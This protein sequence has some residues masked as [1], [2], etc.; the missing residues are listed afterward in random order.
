[1]GH[2]RC[3][4][5]AVKGRH[6]RSERW[7]RLVLLV[8]GLGL[9]LG[10]ITNARAAVLPDP[11]H[12]TDK[13]HMIVIG[14][15][16][17]GGF[18]G[19]YNFHGNWVCEPVDGGGGWGDWGGPGQ[20]G[21]GPEDED[22]VVPLSSLTKSPLSARLQCALNKYT[23]SNAKPIRAI[24]RARGYAYSKGQTFRYTT[25]AVDPVQRQS[26]NIDR[27]MVPNASEV[28]IRGCSRGAGMRGFGCGMS[29]VGFALG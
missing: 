27:M 5:R 9:A 18:T 10:M 15:T 28:A 22:L 11:A 17:P 23:D 2:V 16:C 4:L 25:E 12:G 3:A 19:H 21:D 29:R 26:N 6:R 1:M 20:P 14:W 24:K 13:P 8:S 7:L